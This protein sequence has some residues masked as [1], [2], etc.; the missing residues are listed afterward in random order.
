MTTQVKPADRIR[1]LM[2]K[3]DMTQAQCA[4]YL[5][6]PLGTLLNWLQ[7]AREPNTV[8]TRLLDVLAMLEVLAPGIHA[9]LL[10]P[11]KVK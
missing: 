3:H 2:L 11:R 5:G 9:S 10:P 1:A 7:H 8:I 6:V 4:I